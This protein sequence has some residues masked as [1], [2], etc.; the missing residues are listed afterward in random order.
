MSGFSIVIPVF[1]NWHFTEKAIEDLQRL[2]EDHQIIIVDN[3]S[4]DKT[5]SLVSEGRI[6]VI[7]NPDN[8]G[9]A[10]ACNIGFSCAAD[11]GADAV[12]FLNND[13]RVRSN[14]ETWTQSIL[15]VLEDQ[16]LIGPTV[17]VLDSN[18]NFVTEASKMPSRGVAYMSG[19]NVS[20]KTSTWNKLIIRDYLGPFSEEFGKA[21]FEDTDLGMRATQEG[22]TF[23][24]VDVPV[25]HFGKQTSKKMNTSLLYTSARK[26]FLEKWGGK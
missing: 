22:M 11:G 23:K 12:M 3:G 25:H 5:K 1:N 19:W 26:I 17:G 6:R 9:F 15:E 4:S 16:C 2:P 18:L 8:Y 7:R 10:R 13:I 21:Y 20:A 14:H 24:I